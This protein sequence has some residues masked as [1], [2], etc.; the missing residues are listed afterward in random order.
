MSEPQC[1]ECGEL[2][3]VTIEYR[4]HCYGYCEAHRAD[5]ELEVQR[6]RDC[7]PDQS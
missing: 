4:G 5:M 2:A 6:D 1:A 3:T 7:G